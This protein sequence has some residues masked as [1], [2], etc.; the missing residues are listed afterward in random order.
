MSDDSNEVVDAVHVTAD[1]EDANDDASDGESI[2]LTSI[3]E[4]DMIEK[5]GISA[6]KCLW[7]QKTFKGRHAS[8]ATAH[9]AKAKGLS[10]AVRVFNM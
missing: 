1:K 10:I 5:D 7:C 9:L 6:W 2:H 3:W 8:K 4:D